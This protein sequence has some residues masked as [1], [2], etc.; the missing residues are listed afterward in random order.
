MNK[1][2]FTHALALLIG[3][4]LGYLVAKKM[5]EDYYAELAQEE[6]DSV[7]EMYERKLD[8]ALEESG[9]TA[10]MTQEQYEE[11]H[12]H[13][14]SPEKK[15]GSPRSKVQFLHKEGYTITEIADELGMTD[16][17]VQDYLEPVVKSPLVRKEVGSKVAYHQMAKENMREQLE[18]PKDSIEHHNVFKQAGVRKEIEPSD[19]E[20]EEPDE[21]Q[22]YTARDLSEIDRTSPYVISAD[23][24]NDEFVEHDKLS[25]YYYMVDDVLCDEHEEIMDDIDN[26]VGYDVFRVLENQPTAWVRNERL[27]I[28][29]EI[30]VVRSSYAEVVQGVPHKALSPREQYQNRQRRRPNDDE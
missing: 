7:K 1:K 5:L 6:I 13:T 18:L 2:F 27:A 12:A 22:G 19:E 14:S 28:D 24:Y 8:K 26:T 30:C 17:E 23:E 20:V 25:I 10:E 15:E 3:G 21:P 16:G 11:R 29:Y 9:D 4:G